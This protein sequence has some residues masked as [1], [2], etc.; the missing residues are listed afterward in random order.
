MSKTSH[1][2]SSSGSAK[3]VYVYK[4]LVLHVRQILESVVLDN[5]LHREAIFVFNDGTHG[6]HRIVHNFCVFAHGNTLLLVFL[7]KEIE[8]CRIQAKRKC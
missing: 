3:L 5:L 4:I 6:M 8:I 2:L 1:F 7:I